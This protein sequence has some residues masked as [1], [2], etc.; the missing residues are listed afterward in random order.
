MLLQQTLKHWLVKYIKCNCI[1]YESIFVHD[2][3][4]QNLYKCTCIYAGVFYLFPA[5][6]C[7]TKSGSFSNKTHLYPRLVRWNRFEQPTI[8]PPIKATSKDSSICDY[9]RTVVNSII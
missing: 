6:T 8:P 2:F 1:R 7:A 4:K 3:L 5:L 9:V